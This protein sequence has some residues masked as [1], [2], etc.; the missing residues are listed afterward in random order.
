MTNGKPISPHGTTGRYTNHG[1]RCDECRAA[2][3]VYAKA[4][5]E[6]NRDRTQ[7]SG[8]AWRESHQEQRSAVR[9]VY[10][11]A[12]RASVAAKNAEW[13][14]RNPDSAKRR[15]ADWRKRNPAKSSES[16]RTWREAN[17]DRVRR[18]SKLW[19]DRNRE[20]T[21]IYS[22]AR[23]A[24]RAG[25]DTRT[26][27][28]SDWTR[29][30][31][32]YSGS[33]AYCGC[34]PERLTQDHIVPLIRGGRHAIGNLLPACQSCNSSKATKLLIEWLRLRNHPIERRDAG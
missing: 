29:L 15:S 30:I 12:N 20:L 2:Q 5:R 19:T 21:V 14:R 23:R 28:A 13:Q 3:A 26:V 34:K 33:C 27:T 32:R 7:K 16:T 25:T 4:W 22:A 9:H 18:S 17:R 24:R 6:A 8:A 10:Y 1:C 11:E 31:A